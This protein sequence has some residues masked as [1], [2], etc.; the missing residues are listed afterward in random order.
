MYSPVNVK[1]TVLYNDASRLTLLF[2]PTYRIFLR[3]YARRLCGE[4]CEPEGVRGDSLV[5]VIAM[6]SPQGMRRIHHLHYSMP[7]AGL[8]K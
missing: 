6:P 7:K 2:W 4:A 3:G 1:P 5:V 8:P